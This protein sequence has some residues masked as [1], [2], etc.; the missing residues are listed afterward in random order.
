MPRARRVIAV[1]CALAALAAC[2]EQDPAGV[3]VKGFDDDLVFGVKEADASTA[4]AA[5]TLTGSETFSPD[6]L[7]SGLDLPPT[8]F[9][10]GP[11]V[12]RLPITAARRQDPCPPAD[13]TDSPEEP[14]PLTVP[15]DRRPGLGVYRWK[16]GGNM[17]I[18]GAPL[19]LT[20]FEQRLV[21]DLQEHGP[22]TNTRQVPG[23]VSKEGVVFSFE[24]VQPDIDGNV[25]I[26]RYRIDTEP[27]GAFTDPAATGEEVRTGSP[28]RGVVLRELTIEDRQGNDV[29]SFS[30]V[31]GLLLLPLPVRAGENFT[32]SA[33]DPQTGNTATF[34]AEVKDRQ[35]VDVCGELIEA[36]VVKGT[37]TFS[38]EQ[39]VSRTYELTIATGLGGMP[40]GEKV[41][42][43][44]GDRELHLVTTLGQLKPDP[45]Q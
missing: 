5:N 1:A 17:T 24:T 30:P 18:S 8:A 3:S 2:A 29:M 41:D 45:V 13:A 37:Q 21:R 38:G 14:A 32:S 4:T 23:S 39:T 28:E 42:Q 43:K 35:L 22:S 9:S 12:R 19:P 31:T 7:A 10:S 20:G 36:W 33:V 16:R 11:P 15:N 34:E 44:E 27:A 6:T 40:V 26:S 25:V